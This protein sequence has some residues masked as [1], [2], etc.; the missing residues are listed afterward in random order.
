MNICPTLRK[1][2]V[3][4][5]G[6]LSFLIVTEI[7]LI[8]AYVLVGL[9]SYLRLCSFISSAKGL[10]T[11]L[12][13]DNTAILIVV[14]LNVLNS[15]VPT[16]TDSLVLYLLVKEKASHSDIKIELVFLMGTPIFLKFGRLANAMM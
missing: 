7:A 3:K 1:A 4:L 10:F 13:F 16:Y 6:Y 11:D 14:I 12:P 8:S 9:L 2:T 5:Y 15:L